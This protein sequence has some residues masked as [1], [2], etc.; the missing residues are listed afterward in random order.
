MKRWPE[1]IDLVL[2]VITVFILIFVTLLKEAQALERDY[3]VKWCQ[4]YSGETEYTLLDKVRVDCMLDRYAIEFD[5]GYK[6]AESI[7]QS[8]LYASRT[9][10]RPGIVLIMQSSKDCK[11]LDRLSEAIYFGRLGITVWQT[12]EYAYLCAP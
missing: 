4:Q 10:T 1:V 5:F 8:L 6:W 7:G 12:G 11:Y 9:D 2:I 3:Q